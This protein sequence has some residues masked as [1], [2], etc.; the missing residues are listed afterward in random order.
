[1]DLFLSVGLQV[2]VFLA[3]GAMALLVF[4]QVDAGAALKRR[5][6]ERA[7]PGACSRTPS[8]RPRS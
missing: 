7:A 4:R 2:A 8:P 1:M 3:V 5:M 6:R